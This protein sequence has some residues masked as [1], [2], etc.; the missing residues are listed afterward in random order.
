MRALIIEDNPSVKRTL[1]TILADECPDVII[2]GTAG[3]VQEGLSLVRSSKIDLIFLDIEMPDGS[4]FDL[5]RQLDNLDF[6][7]IFITAHE[8]YAI[9]AIKFSALDFLLKPIDPDDVIKAVNKAESEINKHITDQKLDALFANIAKDNDLPKR[10]AL[11]DKYGVQFVKIEDIVRLKG[12]G[13]Y[14]TFFIKSG[15]AITISK[16]LKEYESLLLD[17]RF[18]RCHQSHLVNLEYLERYDRREGDMLILKG[19]VAVPLAKRKKD[20]LSK[21]LGL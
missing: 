10:I 8:K 12:D 4:G 14:T 17:H 5:L 11:K 20:E 9:Q 1:Q 15:E 18:F 13:N 21:L 2:E 19:D 16:G 6:Q 3:N 7:V